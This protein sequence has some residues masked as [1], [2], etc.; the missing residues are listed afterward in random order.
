MGLVYNISTMKDLRQRIGDPKQIA[1][2]QRVQ[3]QEGRGRGNELLF[4]RNGSGLTF[5][6]SISRAFDIG[7]CELFSIPISWLSAAGP[8]SPAFYEK[9]G[10]EWNRSFEGGLLATGGLTYMGKPNVDEG[11]ALGL[12]GR[13]SSTPAELLRSEA[14]QTNDTYE[15]M[16]QGRV[17]QSSAIGEHITLTRTIRTSMGINRISIVDEI[18]NEAFSPVEHM[19]LYHFNL[20][21]PLISETCRIHI[22]EAQTRRWIQGS[23]P[24]EGWDRFKEPS[25]R[26]PTVLLHEGVQDENGWIQISVENEVLL[27]NREQTLRVCI[28][29][30]REACPFLSQWQ[31]ST[32]GEYVLG[33]EPGNTSTEGRALHRKRGTLPYLQPQETRRY[34]FLVDFSLLDECIKG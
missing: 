14:V 15:L 31:N 22:P 29:Y 20:G 4:V 30:P 28:C 21:F 16:F 24:L 11:E 2:Y 13:I 9:D 1:G 23:G 3:L 18:T 27:N 33:L 10:R 34:E 32:R 6:I 19:V 26:A 12:H 5:Q 17:R 25:D 7:L 8:V